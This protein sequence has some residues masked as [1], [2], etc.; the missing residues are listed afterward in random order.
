MSAEAE[1]LFSLAKKILNDSQNSLHATIIKALECM[2][3]W[4]RARYYIT[5]SEISEIRQVAAGTEAASF[6]CSIESSILEG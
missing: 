3:S 6:S 4:L 5:V 2:K 1:R